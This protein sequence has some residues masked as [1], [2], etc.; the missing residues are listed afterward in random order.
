MVPLRAGTREV[1]VL[2]RILR[3]REIVVVIIKVSEE[4]VGTMEGKEKHEKGVMS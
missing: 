4:R 1:V 3:D 2:G